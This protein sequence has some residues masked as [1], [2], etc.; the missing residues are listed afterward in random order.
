M[1]CSLRRIESLT[2]C[3]VHMSHLLLNLSGML[4]SL[5]QTQ[6]LMFSLASTGSVHKR[7][8]GTISSLFRKKM[9]TTMMSMDT[10]ASKSSLISVMLL[11]PKRLILNARILTDMLI[12]SKRMAL[13]TVSQQVKMPRMKLLSLRSKMLK[14]ERRQVSLLR[15]KGRMISVKVASMGSRSTLTATRALV[16]VLL[17]ILSSSGAFQTPAY[18]SLP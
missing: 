11:M 16:P 17:R 3:L 10:M 13:A 5:L 9:V 7:P 2:L 18:R 8:N 15:S 14:L 4:S 6:A 12:C 1:S